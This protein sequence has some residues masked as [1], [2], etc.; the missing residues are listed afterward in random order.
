MRDRVF[1]LGRGSTGRPP[2]VFVPEGLELHLHSCA[3]PGRAAETVLRAA[4]GGASGSSVHRTGGRLPNWTL[5]P[6]AAADAARALAL[7]P[8]TIDLVVAGGTLRLCEAP[9]RCGTRHDCGGWLDLLGGHRVLHLLRCEDSEDE[10]LRAAAHE[11]NLVQ[12]AWSEDGARL[13]C[14]QTERVLVLNPLRLEPEPHGAAEIL[15]RHVAG[16]PHVADAVVVRHDEDDPAVRWLDVRRSNPALAES[17]QLHL[18]DFGPWLSVRFYSSAWLVDLDSLSLTGGPVPEEVDH[19]LR[20]V[21]ARFNDHVRAERPQLGA[22]RGLLEVAVDLLDTRQAVADEIRDAARAVHR[23]VCPWLEELKAVAGACEQ[24]LR[25]LAIADPAQRLV[26]QLP[27]LGLLPPDLE[28]VGRP[29]VEACVALE[30]NAFRREAHACADAVAVARERIAREPVAGVV[31]AV[32]AAIVP[33]LGL[34]ENAA[35][36]L[37]AK[38]EQVITSVEDDNDAVA[39]RLRA[40]ACAVSGVTTGG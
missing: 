16:L 15:H 35:A 38:L 18:G 24:V 19:A 28:P 12:L 26:T 20:A 7:T 8:A 4:A 39:R 10:L 33:W 36:E 22:L 32:C 25:D 21:L 6:V 17:L 37:L 1:L 34:A 3:A 30:M 29:P 5:R 11:H 13:H 2:E 27:G 40:A 23:Q 9:L 31:V 14:V